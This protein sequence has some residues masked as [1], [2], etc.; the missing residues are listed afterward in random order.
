M[1]KYTNDAYG[2]LLEVSGILK[3]SLGK[4]NPF[5][6]KGY[7]YDFETG[8]MLIPSNDGSM[9]YDP[10]IG[11]YKSTKDISE[12]LPNDMGGLNLYAYVVNNP[13]TVNAYTESI[14][15]AYGTSVVNS[16]IAGG[17]GGNT[18]GSTGDKRWKLAKLPG[19]IDPIRDLVNAGYGFNQGA[20]VA[21]YAWKNLSFFDDMKMF[22]NNPTKSING[23]TGSFWS[24][25]LGDFVFLGLDIGFDIYDSMQ[26]GLSWQGTAVGAGLTAIKG[27]AMIYTGKGIIYGATAIGSLIFPG[28]G[29]I[30]GFIVGVGVAIIVDWKLGK[31][32]DKQIEKAKNAIG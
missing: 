8:L 23:L 21:Y 5:L 6:Y 25:G 10:S 2:N 26:N 32:L 27:V 29:T 16:M 19:F 22:G 4:D 1:L 7:Y 28:I 17:V 31:W 12:L 11:R 18:G 13:V 20:Q 15:K 9:Y 14:A 24:L 30:R 3:D